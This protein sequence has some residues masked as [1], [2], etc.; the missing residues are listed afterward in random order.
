MQRIT[1]KLNHLEWQIKQYVRY[2]SIFLP[3][4]HLRNYNRTS[5]SFYLRNSLI[6]IDGQRINLCLDKVMAP[7]VNRFGYWDNGISK[8][9]SSNLNNSDKKN[10]FLDIGA[11]QGLVTLQVIKGCYNIKNTE[12]ILLE[13]VVEFFGN[14]QKNLHQSNSL[15]SYTSLNFGLGLISNSSAYSF[16]SKRNSTS[17]QHINLSLDPKNKL[18]IENITI[19][20]VEQFIASYLFTKTF[21][22]LIVKSD[23]DGSDLE[24]F[25]CFVNSTIRPKLTIYILEVVLTTISKAGLEIFVNNC[26]SF[27]TWILILRN[28]KRLEDKQSIRNILENE[29]NYVGDLYLSS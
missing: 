20:S 29:Q 25:D 10:I 27:P 22:Q 16:T 9:I 24:I 4:G 26:C 21:D 13:P 11:N 5:G 19:I 8:F 15:A 12:F 7:Y 6:G 2:L 14:L 28:G 23:T 3:F 1:K 17:T 18:K